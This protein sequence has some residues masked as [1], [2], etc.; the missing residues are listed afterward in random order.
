MSAGWSMPP[1][2]CSRNLRERTVRRTGS[3]LAV[4]L[5]V[6]GWLT[7][8]ATLAAAPP[9]AAKR[10]PDVSISVLDVSPNTPKVSVTPQPLTFTV[11]L[12]NNSFE[13]Q[14]VTVTVD[15]S[16][17]IGSRAQLENALANP[18]PPSPDQVAPLA[19]TATKTLDPGRTTVVALHTVTSTEYHTA[20]DHHGL[21][22]CIDAIYPIWFTATYQGATTS[23]TSNTQTYV[24]AFNAA[25]AKSRVSWVWPLL[26]RPRR[27]LQ[28]HVFADDQLAEEV[29][30]GRLARLLDVAAQVSP[31]VPMT[32]LTD[33][34]LIDELIVMTKGYR[35]VTTDGH[36]VQGT[37]GQAAQSWLA[38]LH[39]VLADH[40]NVQLE[41]TPFADPAV[42][43]LARSGRGWAVKLDQT[44]T[45]DITDTL[46]RTAS[47]GLAWPVHGLLSRVA[48][49]DLVGQG[50]NTIIT[51]DRAFGS[52]ADQPP[53]PNALTAMNTRHGPATLA[54]TSSEVEPLISRAMN[55]SGDG[56]SVLPQLVAQL[57]MDSVVDPT[58]SRYLVLTP[59]RNDLDVD[60]TAA[61]RTIDATADTTWSQPI[62]I[63]HEVTSG[64]PTGHLALRPGLQ[65]PSLSAD[66]LE[67]LGRVADAV[68]DLEKLYDD[69]SI[70]QAI[71][72]PF[73]AAI[74][75][76]E[77]S[78]LIYHPRT[79][80]LF[81]RHL[82]RV[83]DSTRAS[84]Y[85]VRPTSGTYT[86][87]SE[88]AKLPITV[89]NKLNATVDV[90]LQVTSDGGLTAENPNKTNIIPA[91]SKVQLRIPTHVDRVGVIRVRVTIKT[92]G[93]TVLGPTINLKVRSTTLGAI[94]VI[95]TIV[96]AV[97]L[98]IAVLVRFLRRLRRKPDAQPAAPTAPSTPVA[99]ASPR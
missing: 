28:S 91:N 86:L 11:Q 43:A 33:P 58:Q 54:V 97:L 34:D 78:A 82:A 85:L 63:E 79:A 72:A 38:E 7:S 61:V 16:D 15:R 52:G 40:P 29:S 93:Q 57:A 45:K 76:C 88:N 46:G 21:C 98:A 26:D 94:G 48:L 73:P 35:V 99:P 44:A 12:T 92:T 39:G 83:V 95:I 87:T 36:L 60:V 53:L 2:G 68:P 13:Q 37:G 24:P 10:P 5:L 71:F 41:F 81:A 4:V 30:T 31:D 66:L 25:P 84:V 14:H 62:P 70:G 56:L 80:F 8:L 19:A 20:T 64:A 65:G 22:L 1:G 55:I 27:L 75:R 74:Q 3:C 32:I 90:K 96:A 51:A 6:A 89:V 42:D 59:P 69:R 9:A 77:S 49:S 50:T 23:G 47:T 18:Q 67:T 17:P